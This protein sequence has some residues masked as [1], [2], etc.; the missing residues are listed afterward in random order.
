LSFGSRQ[1]A[2]NGIKRLGKTIGTFHQLK[3]NSKFST[4][5]LLV[6]L[7]L[8]SAMS[9]AAASPNPQSLTADLACDGKLDQALLILGSNSVS[10]RLKFATRSRKPEAFTF[11]VGNSQADICALPASLQEESLDFDPSVDTGVGELAGFV[12]SKTCKGLV[13]SVGDCDPIHF[14]WDHATHSMRWWR[15]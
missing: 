9:M 13:L 5:K 12:R 6:R 15:E 10:V 1:L 4:F 8:S 3:R 2:F 11:R 7:T 14:Y